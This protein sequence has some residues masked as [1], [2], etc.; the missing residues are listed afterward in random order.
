MKELVEK[1][2]E[3]INNDLY[4]LCENNIQQLNEDITEV[5][6][7]ETA[8]YFFNAVSATYDGKKHLFES[9]PTKINRMRFDM[10]NDIASELAGKVV[11]LAANKGADS[12]GFFLK[13]ADAAGGKLHK[14]ILAIGK[15]FGLK[16]KPWQAVKI[17][18]NIGNVAKIIGPLLEAAGLAFEIKEVIDEQA[19]PAKIQQAKNECRQNFRDIANNIEEEYNEEMKNAY[20]AYNE[21]SAH[22]RDGRSKVEE[23]V[24]KNSGMTAELNT[25]RNDLVLI[26][27][28]IF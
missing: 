1:C 28:E 26:Q 19:L 16:F 11:K 2:C 21:I 24:K 8:C 18:K 12:A 20:A 27:R 13:A 17:A 9:K 4:A 10:I 6:N 14:C 23:I 3:K 7:G 5:L 15:N 25:I 22:I